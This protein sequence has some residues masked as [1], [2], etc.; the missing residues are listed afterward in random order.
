MAIDEV[1][2]SR[3]GSDDLD[4]LERARK[5][6]RE[7]TELA[8]ALDL[9]ISSVH[10]SQDFLVA[11]SDCEVSPAVAARFL[12][13]S[14]P[15]L[16]KLLDVGAIP[17]VTVGRDRRIRMHDLAAFAQQREA[18]RCELAET[19]AHADDHRRGVLARLA[20]VSEEQARKA[21]F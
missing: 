4:E 9:I 8:R 14:R 11:A 18:A 13:M 3:V 17:Y 16:Y 10:D 7:G 1:V 20:G 2:A 6:M 12:K 15:H 19:F 5:N 21:G